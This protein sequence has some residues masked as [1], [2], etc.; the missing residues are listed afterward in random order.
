MVKQKKKKRRI[1][2]WIV[3][4]VVAFLVIFSASFLMMGQGTI[5]EMTIGN[6]SAAEVPDGTYT[7][8]FDGYRWS[9]TLQVTVAGG[10]ITGIEMIKDQSVAVPDVSGKLFAAVVEKQSLQVDAVTGATVSSKAY[11]KAIENALAGE[12]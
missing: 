2:L 11:L 10:K 4:G 3:L 9:N 6:V 8:N 1:A 5:K 7:G 12:K